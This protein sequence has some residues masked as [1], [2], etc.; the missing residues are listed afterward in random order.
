MVAVNTDKTETRR[1]AKILTRV[2]EWVVV[3]LEFG[4]V[5][6]VAFHLVLAL[7]AYNLGKFRVVLNSVFF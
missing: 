2:V 3:K 5:G 7:T 1:P 4:W 6:D